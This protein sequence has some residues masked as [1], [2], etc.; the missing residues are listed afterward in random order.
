MEDQ[1]KT[2]IAQE[3]FIKGSVQNSNS[4]EQQ[5]DNNHLIKI[6]TEHTTMLDLI[7]Q[8]LRGE[9]LYQDESGER[10]YV[11]VDKPRF[12][13]LDKYNKPI[14][15]INPKTKKEEY[16]PNDEAINEVLGALKAA[17]LNS[18]TPMTTLSEDII[19]ADL[20]EIQSKVVVA[21]CIKRKS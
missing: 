14:K 18:I 21:L 3:A 1:Q 20:L 12:V 16:V 5:S 19:M 10:Y 15:Q 4:N 7:K 11:Q 6:L 13:K 8:E 17:G 2:D 9:Q